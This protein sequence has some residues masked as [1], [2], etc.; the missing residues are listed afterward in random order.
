M[1]Q[2]VQID[3]A[4]AVVADHTWAALKD[5]ARFS[6]SGNEG[7]NSA[8]T[9]ADL[10]AAA[11]AAMKREG[12][13]AERAGDITKAEASAAGKFEAE[14]RMP[15][16]AHA[17]M[18]PLSCTVKIADGRCDVWVGSQ[19]VGRAQKV[20][21]EAA[22]LPLDRVSIH[23]QYLGGGFGRRLE[24]DYVSQA[25]LIAEAGEVAAESDVES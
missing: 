5:C 14:Y 3:N 1:R 20:T 13:V 22:G 23:N 12:L 15:M 11:D 18:E 6:R 25:V 19:I 2:V 17:A 16:L 7:A 4:V 21:A 24:T 8:L 10:A 9:T